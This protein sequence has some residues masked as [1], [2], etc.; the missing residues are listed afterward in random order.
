MKNKIRQQDVQYKQ[1]YALKEL[2]LKLQLV[3]GYH[4]T[5]H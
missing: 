5:S 3:R 4:A 2:Q 1:L